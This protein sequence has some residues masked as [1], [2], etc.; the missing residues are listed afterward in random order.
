MARSVKEPNPKAFPVKPKV[1]KI[2]QRV[3]KARER[4]RLKHEAWDRVEHQ[5]GGE[6]TRINDG[7][8][9]FDLD[10][11]LLHSTLQSAIP[12]TL[13]TNPQ[14]AAMP[15][16]KGSERAAKIIEKV[17]NYFLDELRMMR[18]WRKC[19][20]DTETYGYGVA[21]LG[22]I[23]SDKDYTTRQDEEPGEEL[24]R[25]LDA[26]EE[27]LTGEE[28]EEGFATPDPGALI[29]PW[30]KRNQ[31]FCERVSP[32]QFLFDPMAR[33]WRCC[34]W[35]GHEYVMPLS[36]IKK[37]KRFREK[38]R[39]AVQGDA[40]FKMDRKNGGLEVQSGI[41][42]SVD[43]PGGANLPGDEEDQFATLIEIWDW[44]NQKLITV[45]DSGPDILQ[46]VDWPYSFEGFPFAI[47]EYNITPDSLI[48]VSDLEAGVPQVEELKYLRRK[49]AIHIRRFNR[50]YRADPEVYEDEES[51]EAMTEGVDGAVV[52][53]SQ[54]SFEAI[55]DAP[56]SFDYDK[57][58]AGVKQ[59]YREITAQSEI[60]RGGSLGSGGTAT[61]ATL[62]QASS[63]L[64]SNYK[65]GLMEEF[66]QDNFRILNALLRAYL[67]TT[68]AVQIV[69]EEEDADLDWIE[70]SGGDIQGEYDVKVVP[71]STVP[72][73]K[74]TRKQSLM[75][76]LQVLAPFIQAGAIPFLPIL[77]EIV[78]AWEIKDKDMILGLQ[79]GQDEMQS[80]LAQPQVMGGP[81][82]S[83]QGGGGGAGG[84]QMNAIAQAIAAQGGI[85]GG[86]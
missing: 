52:K 1:A 85:G 75:Q 45:S 62:L 81:G 24:E 26:I 86:F 32:R 65:R 59:D 83:G 57:H 39:N 5:L 33:D 60:D 84:D 48:P 77:K 13:L 10:V 36:A 20:A 53:G 4:R 18:E 23:P 71:G 16:R 78:E 37:E 6:P 43:A 25:Q 58:E 56:T 73:T 30:K 76:L 74:E 35:M 68:I 15:R 63:Q 44:E 2:L 7:D 79:P 82:I 54:G 34:R 55:Q 67:D 9:Y 72:I 40:R 19:A 49:R 29:D 38:A 21:K 50:K 64:R 14:L 69:G 11:M 61:E 12:R 27:E 42:T 17:D 22:Y 51:M 3:E 8:V 47:L 31:F 80:P 41:Y 28:S 46:E 66:I 70:V